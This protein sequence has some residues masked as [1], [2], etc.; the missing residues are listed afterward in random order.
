MPNIPYKRKQY[1]V[2]KGFQL[3]YVGRIV[4]ISVLSAVI[5]GY[6]IYYNAWIQLGEKLA[7]VY[8]QGQLVDIFK[9]VNLSL[10]VNMIFV[11]MFCIGVG[12]IFSH[13]IAGPIERMKKFLEAVSEG[14]YSQRI[15]LRKKDE[16]KDLSEAMNKLVEKLESEK[17]S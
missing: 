17:K 8:P 4:G 5:S 1:V 15:V 2:K 13:R 6:T 12:I 14:D 10:A 3:R 9:R 7:Y 16:L 11:V